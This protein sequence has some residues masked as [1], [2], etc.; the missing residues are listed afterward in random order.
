MMRFEKDIDLWIEK[1]AGE[2]I[3]TEDAVS[4]DRI[5]EIEKPHIILFERSVQREDDVTYLLVW[6]NGIR[7]LFLYA[8]CV[9]PSVFE[10]I[11]REVGS[12]KL[13]FCP[14]NHKNAAALRTALPY[15]APVP[16]LK[17]RTTF[18]VGDRL[19]IAGPG[20]ICLFRNLE[21]TPILAQ[22]SVR[23]VELT[24]RTFEDVLDAST[25][26]VFQEGFRSRW[27]ADG[28]HL[29]TEEWVR[30][31]LDI[32][33]TMITA[34]VSEFIK[35]EF[36]ESPPQVVFSAYENIDPRYRARVEKTYLSLSVM[37]DTGTE[38]RF[39]KEELARTVLVYRE[40]IDH[41]KRLYDTAVSAV[42]EK[43]FDFELSVDE[44]STP[45]TLQAHVFVVMEL[46]SMGV[47]ISS[48]A[49]RFVGEFQKGIDYIGIVD[50][51]EKSFAMHAA[52]AKKLGHKIS[53]HSGS[54]KFSIFPAVGKYSGG[55]FH[56]KTSGTNWLAALKVIAE[57]RPAFF[58]KL[59]DFALAH[60][61]TAR[62]YYHITPAMENVPDIGDIPDGSL[63]NVFQ[64]RDA[65][66]VLHIS[67]G[68]MFASRRLKAEIFETI[69]TYI[70]EYW[71]E[72]ERHIGRH[73]D[74]LGL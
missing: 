28:D 16:V 55:V 42:G 14:L 33:F 56:I 74:L 22:Q 32:G 13:M 10:G 65:R 68:E 9:L 64:N 49:P 50:E 54:D 7:L 60:F 29:K 72:L 35:D 15:T 63:P 53:I 12:L 2:G 46:R 39:S 21:A 27:G 67:Y 3:I 73:T 57:K 47:S 24:G 1:A 48:L 34:D 11:P 8:H 18:G 23:E 40:A 44:T 17:E 4:L 71:E 61:E 30:K 38:I 19:G 5:G 36:S 51:F 6:L 37:L 58:R 20:H 70:E 62:S 66:Q 69:E 45:T 52:I 59:Y 41:A 43:M 25:W 31:V 26:A